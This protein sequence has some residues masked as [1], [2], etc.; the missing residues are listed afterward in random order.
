MKISIKSVLSAS[1]LALFFTTSAQAV[2]VTVEDGGQTTTTV[3]G[4]SVETFNDG[5]CGTYVS[6]TGNFQI[7][8]G[9]ESGKY[10]QPADTGTKYLS[11]P[12]EGSSGT[13]SLMLGTTANYFGLYWGSIDTYN[14]LTFLLNDQVVDAF[15]GTEIATYIPGAADGNQTSYSS[16]R[17]FNFFFGSQTF[18][19]VQLTSDGYAFETDNHAFA[20]V[21]EPGTLALMA[22]GV[23]GLLMARSR[24]Q[25]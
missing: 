16:N 7:V 13:A 8:S 18:D 10:A 4:A 24:K 11:V 22:L 21:S 5:N 20:T 25:A 2:L 6:C 17:Y 14:T 3:T 19:E 12:R 1:A 23:I 9:S 15:T